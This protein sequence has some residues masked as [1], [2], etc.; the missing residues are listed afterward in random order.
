MSSPHT[1]RGSKQMLDVHLPYPHNT[2]TFCTSNWYTASI[3][4]KNVTHIIH[5]HSHIRLATIS[6]PIRH[7]R[8]VW[9]L[10]SGCHWG[11]RFPHL[12][13]SANSHVSLSLIVRLIW[14]PSARL[15]TTFPT[16]HIFLAFGMSAFLLLVKTLAPTARFPLLFLFSIMFYGIVIIIITT[17]PAQ[18]NKC[19]HDQ[20]HCN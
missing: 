9:G 12:P 13:P 18:F 10:W 20:L 14:R 7:Q 3:I 16:F 1:E 15:I 4:N 5:K 11:A 2:D 8:S 6:P 19:L 17:A